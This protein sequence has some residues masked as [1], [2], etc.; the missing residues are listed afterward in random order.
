[1]GGGLGGD[2]GG[3]GGRGVVLVVVDGGG[4]FRVGVVVVVVRTLD[5]IIDPLLLILIL[6]NLRPRT[7]YCCSPHLLLPRGIAT[8][9]KF[10]F[11]PRM[12]GMNEDG[13]EVCRSF[14]DGSG[15]TFGWEEVGDE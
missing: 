2:V 11:Q 4:G 6:S 12:N 1:M 14:E 5:L 9:Y 3:G 10:E 13:D 7:C 8:P 15:L